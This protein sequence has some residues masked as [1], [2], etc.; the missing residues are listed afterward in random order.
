MLD[1]DSLLSVIRDDIER[2][3]ENIIENAKKEL[4]ASIHEASKDMALKMGSNYSMD[5]IGD[6][7]IIKFVIDPAQRAQKKYEDLI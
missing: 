6:E 4:E 3:K 2:A 7:V 1:T 5:I